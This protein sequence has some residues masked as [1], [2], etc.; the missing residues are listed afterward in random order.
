M[1]KLKIVGLALLTLVVMAAAV[2][3]MV[4]GIVYWLIGMKGQAFILVSMSIIAPLLYWFCM[5]I[6]VWED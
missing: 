3:A 1:R 4:A 6:L 2:S 5:E